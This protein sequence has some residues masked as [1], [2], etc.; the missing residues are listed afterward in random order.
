MKY[1][2]ALFLVVCIAHVAR[3]SAQCAPGIPSAGN[4][5]CLPPDDANSPYYQGNGTQ[6]P[7]P[8]QQLRAIW[9]TRW[10]AIAYDSAT[11]AEGHIVGKINKSEAE[12]A[13]L[14]QCAEHGGNKCKVLVSYYNQCAAVAQVPGGGRITSA[15]APTAKKAEHMA[16]D[17][18]G[19]GTCKIV[20]SACSPAVRVQ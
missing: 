6:Q 10:G 13:V 11:G 12:Q 17:N 3:A 1:F 14:S 20:Y 4:P 5:E 7:A 15:R 18:C 2:I 16:L 9:A 8:P 19:Q